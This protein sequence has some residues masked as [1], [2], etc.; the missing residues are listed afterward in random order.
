MSDGARVG[1]EREI[2]SRTETMEGARL[3]AP[4]RRRWISLMLNPR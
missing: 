3:C 2:F 1:T 4:Y